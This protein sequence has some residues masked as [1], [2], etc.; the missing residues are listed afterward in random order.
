MYLL[1]NNAQL[2]EQDTFMK[3]GNKGRDVL[4]DS[5]KCHYCPWVEI[6]EYRLH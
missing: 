3:N 5:R 6:G 2:G 4:R 1:K